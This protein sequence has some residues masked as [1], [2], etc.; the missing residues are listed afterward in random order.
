MRNDAVAATAAEKAHYDSHDLTRAIHVLGDLGL[1][2]LVRI[3]ATYDAETHPEPKHL[4]LLAA[5]LV[6][7][8][9]HGDARVIQRIEHG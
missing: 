6:F 1:V 8:L 3:F 2:Q 4:T 9:G 5:D 7:F